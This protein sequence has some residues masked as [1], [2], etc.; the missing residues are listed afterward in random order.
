MYASRKVRVNVVT[1]GLIDTPLVNV[2]ADK[3]I[4][5]DYEGFRRTRHAQVPMKRMGT[6]WDI[7]SAVLFLAS[8]E[9]NYITGSE[10][11]MDGG[12]TSSTGEAKL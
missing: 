5:G 12:L 10:L 3:Y 6:S 7:A 1:P 4:G 9:A 11:I 8:K 2:L